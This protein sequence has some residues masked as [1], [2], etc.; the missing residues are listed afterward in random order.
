MFGLV[1]GPRPTPLSSHG[2]DGG[3]AILDQHG[4]H[5]GKDSSTTLAP[6]IA[7]GEE[8]IAGGRAGGGGGVGVGEPHATGSQ[9]INVRSFDLGRAITTE[10]AITDVIAENDNDVGFLRCVGDGSKKGGGEEF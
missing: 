10:V 9:R 2:G 3:R 1:E 6:G 8:R 5:S 4:C 7:P